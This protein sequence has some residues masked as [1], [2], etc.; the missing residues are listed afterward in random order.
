[1][2]D[3]INACLKD[4]MR[5]DPRIVMFGEDVADCSRD[6]YLKDKQ[7]KGKGGVFKLTAGCNAS[8]APRAS[9]IRRWPRPTSWAVP[10]AWPRAG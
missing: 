1:M 5:R 7:V 6:E 2:A 9:S 3:L 8:S 4:E 10:P